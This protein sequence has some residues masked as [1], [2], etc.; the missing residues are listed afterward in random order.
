MDLSLQ[1]IIGREVGLYNASFNPC[2]S[3]FISATNRCR[4]RKMVSRNVSI[5]VLVDLS[6]QLSDVNFPDGILACFNP[7][8]SGFI[9][10][11]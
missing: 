5:L 6:L 10:A 8:F 9:S 7:C 3:G 1:L 11:T 4:N 2:F